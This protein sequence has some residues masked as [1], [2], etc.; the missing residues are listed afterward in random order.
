MS[1]TSSDRRSGA[2]D[3]RSAIIAA[4]LDCVAR[5]GVAKTTVDDISRSAGCSRATLYRMFPG[6]K[7]ALLEAVVGAEVARFFAGIDER[8]AAASTPEELVTSGVE[9]ALDR[10][11]AHAALQYLLAHE[12][13]VVSL[14]PGGPTAQAIVGAASAYAAAHLR[15][16]YDQQAADGL[17]EFVVRMVLSLATLPSA[18]AVGFVQDFV[19]PAVRDQLAAS[20]ALPARI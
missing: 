8:L 7:D 6:G 16:W 1:A 18:R 5:W 10:I 4:T 11:G 9:A 13:E 2:S 12:P 17:A 20:P 14:N 15:R 19:L 3:Q